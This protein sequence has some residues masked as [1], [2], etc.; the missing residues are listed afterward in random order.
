MTLQ[1]KTTLLLFIAFTF[2]S[3]ACQASVDSSIVK[4]FRYIIQLV[5]TDNAKELSRLIAYPLKREN[6]LPDIQNSTE[7]ISEYPLLFDSTLKNLLK[8]YNDS[9]IFEHNFSFGLVG[10]N[11]SGE[12]WL[13][14]NGKIS[15]L[16]SSNVSSPKDRSFKS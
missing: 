8:Q 16:T 7:F 13:N 1:M 5:E 11:F 14:E 4:R 3:N 9:D 15:G 12:I 6:P 2:F 10:G